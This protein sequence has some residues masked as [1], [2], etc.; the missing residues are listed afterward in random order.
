MDRRLSILLSSLASSLLVLTAPLDARAQD[1][2][3]SGELGTVSFPVSCNAEAQEHMHRAVAMLHSFWFPEAR[4]TF[5]AA[6]A[7]D[8]GCGIAYW[9]AAM[10][11]F[12]NPMAGGNAAA[13]QGSGWEAA[14][15]GAAAGARS[16]RDQ[17]YV[18]AAL[19]LFRDY[20]TRSNRE[21][22]Q[23]YTAALSEIV[24]R[25]PEDTE[26]RIFHAI[27][28][29]ATASPTDLSFTQQQ[30]AAEGLIELFSEQPRHP[31]LAHYI[32]HAFDSP[33]LAAN[34]LEAARQ[35]LGIAPAAP[36]ALHMPS[37]IFTRLGY[38]DESI[39]S[40]RRSADLE[41][42]PGAKSH[43]LDYLVYAYL[44]QGRD[45]MASAAIQEI[46]GVSDGDYIAGTLGGYNALAMPARFALERDDWRTAAGL[47]VIPTAP[48][49][50]AVTHFARGLGAARS[51]DV[52]TARAAVA[53]LERLVAAL[54]A[55]NDPY[56]PIVVD[57]Q[58]MAVLAWIAHAEG[59]HAEAL[60]Q[61]RLAA[62]K[63]ETVEK[64]PVTPGPLVPARELFGDLLAEH[65]DPAGAL[66]AYQATL[67][68]EPNRAR[69]LIAAA[70]AAR[71][72]GQ[73]DLARTYY[74]AVVDLMD[75]ASS[76][77]E[78]REASQYLT[79]V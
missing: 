16:P 60:Y 64:H 36:H 68:R 41:P 8:P 74:Q 69:T 43:P 52:A 55:Q 42:A 37:H 2:D 24:E 77:P 76:R 7:A 79:G 47:R 32:I 20:A 67:E 6:A 3:H 40:N 72:G 33:P 51:G 35:Y 61:A 66:A 71:A 23:A 12:G 53:E 45:E 15:R 19:V 39:A 13:S 27:Y 63:E 54:T 56:W 73:G 4:S 25:Y 14:Q 58:R 9:G 38:W 17:A 22:M 59:D 50:E 18:D 1:H 5:E 26:A 30:R 78:L 48:P 11:Y 44:Q 46:A 62:E 70:R 21:R 49:A 29:V 10:T 28:L 75:P 31:G 34:A 65:G 57:A